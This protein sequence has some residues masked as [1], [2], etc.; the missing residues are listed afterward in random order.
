ML[1]LTKTGIGLLTRQYRSVLHKCWMIN[2]GL[3]Q[4]MGDAVSKAVSVPAR[5]I[6]SLLSGGALNGE[7]FNVLD[8]IL[9][10]RLFERKLASLTAV[11][12]TIAAAT[13]P[14]NAEAVIVIG[15][16]ETFTTSD[17]YSNLAGVF[18]IEGGYLT[19]DGSTISNNTEGSSL[20]PIDDISGTGS[21]TI[22]NAK[23]LNNTGLRGG[24]INADTGYT[25]INSSFESNSAPE[26]GV[27]LSDGVINITGSTFKD[28]VSGNRGGAYYNQL[29]SVIF[30]GT[31][32][33]SNNK[34]N[35]SLNDIYNESTISIT[36]GTTTL[37]SGYI[38]TSS[39]TFNVNSGGTL[40]MGN[41]AAFS[42]GILNINS[43]GIA[44]MIDSKLQAA[45][46]TNAGTLNLTMDGTS[47]TAQTITNTGTLKVIHP[48][49]Q[50]DW[51]FNHNINNSGGGT[52]V[53]DNLYTNNYWLQ[54]SSKSITGGTVEINPSKPN[55]SNNYVYLRGNNTWD[56]NNLKVYGALKL[57]STD[58]IT[59][60][61]LT[62]TGTS[63]ISN[64]GTFTLEGS[65]NNSLGKFTGS[66]ILSI[67]NTGTTTANSTISNAINIV[68]GATVSGAFSN[69]SGSIT[70]NGTLS[71]YGTISKAV[72]GSGTTRLTGAT[73]LTS[74]S[75]LSGQILNMNGQTLTM[76]NTGS[77]SVSKLTGGGN[78]SV[79]IS[80]SSS[81]SS[82][83]ASSSGSSGTYTITAINGTKPNTPGTYTYNI[84]TGVNNNTSLELGSGLSTT[85]KTSY[86]YTVIDTIAA[87]TNWDTTYYS[88]L[89]NQPTI[90][91]I[92][93]NNSTTATK[94]LKIS[95]ANNGSASITSTTPLGDTL[96]LVTT[97]TNNASRIFSTTDATAEYLLSTN[98]GAVNAV[99]K[100]LS[101]NG[102]V[103]G[104]NRSTLNLG[105]YNGFVLDSSDDNLSLSSMKVSGGNDYS[106]NLADSGSKLDVADVVMDNTAA[107]ITGAGNVEFTGDNEINAKVLNTGT[108]TVSSGTTDFNDE[109]AGFT[110]AA[111]ATVSIAADDITAE[112]T[113]NG[114]LELEGGNVTT[115]LMGTGRMK[116]MSG[117]VRLLSSTPPA[118]TGSLSFGSSSDYADS[119]LTSS[120]A[121]STSDHALVTAGYLDNNYYMN[122]GDSMAKSFIKAANDNNFTTL[123]CVKE[124]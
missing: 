84:L 79:Y 2:V 63:G 18:V 54:L 118:T 69:F 16:G 36:G 59:T 9:L 41:S 28:N 101:I 10:S 14:S 62:N 64:D 6:A 40:A 99:Y 75:Y 37:N 107:P 108:T 25:I 48:N 39:A 123:N 95:V 33:F 92:T 106:V 94:K 17:N 27:I 12:L 67:K 111:P 55:Y 103:S 46:I 34:A 77:R 72:S 61:A 23:F 86:T 96:A 114:T 121:A 5:L 71:T 97:A 90:G 38:G 81:A 57:S 30:S 51:Y 47:Y 4:A 98:L 78:L 53:F 76:S 13:M 8:E 91:T 74:G 49:S 93:R 35:G 120:S 29:G 60:D 24:V 113:N 20:A 65:G 80:G 22:K 52:V 89:M 44:N 32:T 58:K 116:L 3:W 109:V 83:A 1:K 45:T 87:N 112:T 105:N 110:V 122:Y 82:I 7:A 70:N 11:G 26:G 117:N 56:I 19:I 88:K 119:I 104:N 124:A 21:V 43:G 50:V 115:K 15:P 42:G 31:N 85:Y 100:N 68:S 102:T 73:T 66:G